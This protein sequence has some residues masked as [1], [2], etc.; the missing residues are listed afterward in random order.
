M[1]GVQ[2]VEQG[3]FVG[4]EHDKRVEVCSSLIGWY[5]VG[6]LEGHFDT[7]DS[8]GGRYWWMLVVSPECWNPS[9]KSTDGCLL[10]IWML[11]ATYMFNGVELSLSCMY[12]FQP[13]ELHQM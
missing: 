11:L 7:T 4:R 9:H 12:Y 5:M 2:I 6:L 8:G 3:V 10:M 13:I 1:T